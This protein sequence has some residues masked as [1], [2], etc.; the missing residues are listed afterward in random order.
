[1]LAN[2]HVMENECIDFF[3]FLS[4]QSKCPFRWKIAL[5]TEVSSQ[6]LE[7][8]RDGGISLAIRAGTFWYFLTLKIMFYLMFVI[9]LE[10]EA[11][12]KIGKCMIFWI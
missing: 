3:N 7:H 10:T 2:Y 4:F 12:S 11:L 6:V 1:M 9:E 8:Y 5:S